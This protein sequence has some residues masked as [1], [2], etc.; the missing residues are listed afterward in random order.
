MGALGFHLWHGF[1][2]AFQTLGLNHLKY[3]G[4]IGVIGK[5]FSVIVPLLFAWI[6]VSMYFN[7]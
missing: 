6:P 1:I 4:V 7:L 2:S 5:A 3:N